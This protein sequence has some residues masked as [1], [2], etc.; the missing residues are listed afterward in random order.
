MHVRYGSAGFGGVDDLVGDLFR[1]DWHVSAIARKSACPGYR[2]RD[3]DL[4]LHGTTS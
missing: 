3:Y 1:R 4:T 2:T